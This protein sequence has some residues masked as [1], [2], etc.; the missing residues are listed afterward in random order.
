LAEE[1]GSSLAKFSMSATRVSS[2]ARASACSTHSTL[3]SSV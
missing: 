1:S 2:S 3:Q